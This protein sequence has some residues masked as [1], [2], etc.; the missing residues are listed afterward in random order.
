MA[1]LVQT[2]AVQGVREISFSAFVLGNVNASPGGELPTRVSRIRSTD[3]AFKIS[4]AEIRQ[5]IC[6]ALARGRKQLDIIDDFVT[7]FRRR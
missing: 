6:V 5:F 7:Q 1:F 2:G 3:D 4:Y